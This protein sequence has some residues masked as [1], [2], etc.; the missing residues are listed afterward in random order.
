MS[1]S[2]KSKCT[3]QEHHANEAIGSSLLKVLIDQSPAHYWYK[4]NNKTE[5]TPTQAFGSAIHQALLEPMLFKEKMIVE[6]VFGG[7]GSRAAREEWHLKNHGKTII[8]ADQ[9]DAI[10]GILKSITNHKQACKLISDGHAEESLF[11]T[12]EN[13]V[14]CKARPDFVRE[15]HILVDI[16]STIDASYES[17]RKD[18]ANYSYHVQAALYLD[19]ATAVFGTEFTKFIIIACEKTAPFGVNCFSLGQETIEEGRAQYYKALETLKKCQDSKHYPNYS[20]NEIMPIGLPSWAY[21]N[22]E[23]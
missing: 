16:K 8:K 10:E 4:K 3:I 17:F 20:D 1:K 21:K 22:T 7:T 13:G 5:P 12:H 19:G 18:I 6:P 14:A 2:Y 11:W 23:E 15:G 9:L